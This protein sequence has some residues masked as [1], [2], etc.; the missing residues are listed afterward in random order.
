MYSITVRVTGFFAK[1]IRVVCPCGTEIKGRVSIF[2]TPNIV[3]IPYASK[4][5][6]NLIRFIERGS[7]S[8]ETDF[9]KIYTSKLG[10]TFI[11]YGSNIVRV[12]YFGN[13]KRYYE[14]KR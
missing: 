9:C 6:E 8:Y 14:N 10:N 3:F 5:E 11:Y 2:G 12:E 7:V 1:K 13:A 4:E